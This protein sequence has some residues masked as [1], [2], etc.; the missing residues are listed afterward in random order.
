MVLTSATSFG[1]ESDLWTCSRIQETLKKQFDI[2]LSRCTVWRRLREAQLTY[3]KPEK[4]Y[5]EASEEERK[6][7]RRYCLPKIK[8]AVLKYKAILYF[9]DEST[10]QLGALLG[11]TWSPKGK[12]P[13][14]E[15]TGHRGSI[16]AMSSIAK[17][18]K[19]IFKLYNKR[20]A[21]DEVIEFLKQMLAYHPRRHLA[22]VMDQAPPHTSKKNPKIY[23]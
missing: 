18:G 13:V 19:L 6:K 22:I 12:R 1:Y 9:Q 7:W 16:S 17:N 11:K 10:I 14:S 20:I 15:V 3:Q 21:S 2:T 23:S 5:I 8:R 4:R